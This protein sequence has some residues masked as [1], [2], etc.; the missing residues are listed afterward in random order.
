MRAIRGQGHVFVYSPCGIPF[1]VRLGVL[2]GAKLKVAWFDPRT[3]E[4]HAQ[5]E[6]LNKEQ[7]RFVPPS[8]GR[9]DDWVL[10]LDAV[11]G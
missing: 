3:G 9:G 8:S 2:S 6:I 4:T 5:G 7:A 1:S 10:V 11:E